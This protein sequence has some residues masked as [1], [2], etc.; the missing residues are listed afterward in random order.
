MNSI[1]VMIY[2]SEML[3]KKSQIPQ[4]MMIQYDFVQCQMLKFENQISESKF[5]ECLLT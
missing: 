3:L 1:E 5:I 4:K 2:H